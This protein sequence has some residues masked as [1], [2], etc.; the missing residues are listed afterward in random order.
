MNGYLQGV[1]TQTLEQAERS[2]LS[3]PFLL[4]LGQVDRP[5]VVTLQTPALLNGWPCFNN[6]PFEARLKKTSCPNTII[7]ERALC[8]RNLLR[9]AEV[10]LKDSSSFICRRSL[11]TDRDRSDWN[12]SP[13]R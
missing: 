11:S 3:S 1:C 8:H 12:L 9:G 5:P 4:G 13:R 10:K 7:A 6:Q 2:F